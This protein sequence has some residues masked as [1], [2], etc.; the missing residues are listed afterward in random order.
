MREISDL[1][2]GIA[3]ALA[4]AALFGVGAPLAKLLLAETPPQMLAGLFYLGAGLGL[5]AIHLARASIGIASPEA[6]LRSTDIGWL[7]AI[8]LFGGIVGPTCLMLGLSHSDAGAASLLLNLEG[9]ATMAIAWLVYREHVNAWLLLGALSI[10]SG[11][12]VLSWTHQTMRLD[13]GALL[14]ALA[15][16][17]WGIDNKLTRKLSAADPLVIAAIK[18]LVAGGVN[19][20]LALASGN[21]MPASGTAAAAATVGFFTIGVSL[22]FFVLALRHL[23]AARTAAYFSLAPFIGV[24]VAIALLHEA[25]TPQLAIAGVLMGF[26]LWLHLAEQHDHEHTHDRLEHDHLHRHDE[27]HRHTHDGPVTEPHSH[28]HRH[29]P[30]RH[31]HPHY[32]DIHHRHGHP[33]REAG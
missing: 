4:S 14:I 25:I 32:P 23:G 16:L 8:V 5:G 19:V 21:T 9:I 7:A 12:V 1:N 31:K 24:G 22:V 27:H 26:G 30:I 28:W 29:E 15:C 3:L 20:G 11:A 33:H 17:A 18:G 10:V 6:P 2:R 13:F